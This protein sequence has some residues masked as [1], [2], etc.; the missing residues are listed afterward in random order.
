MKEK[1]DKATHYHHVKK[2][3]KMENQVGLIRELHDKTMK[4]KFRHFFPN[5]AH[6]NKSFGIETA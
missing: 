3:S 6:W 2:I 5:K 4:K 1:E